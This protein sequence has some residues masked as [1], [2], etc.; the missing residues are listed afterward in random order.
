MRRV[1]GR[2]AANALHIWTNLA[3]WT[4]ALGSR[5]IIPPQFRSSLSVGVGV[6]EREVPM[7]KVPIVVGFDVAEI[8]M[9]TASV[10]LI[11]ALVYAI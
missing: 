4:N 9:L 11:A 1:V 8:L 5:N 6:P 3:G 7:S 10:L 2:R